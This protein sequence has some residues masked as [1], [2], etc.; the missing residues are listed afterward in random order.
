MFPVFTFFFSRLHKS[1][2]LDLQSKSFAVRA[3]ITLQLPQVISELQ[4][5]FHLQSGPIFLIPF[6]KRNTQGFFAIT[7]LSR[8]FFIRCLCFFVC[9]SSSQVQSLVVYLSL[10]VASV[11]LQFFGFPLICFE[12]DE[13]DFRINF[14]FLS[15]A[16]L[17]LLLP[18]S[19]LVNLLVRIEILMVSASDRSGQ[20]GNKKLC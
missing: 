17:L 13:F 1:L 8:R 12:V 18:P 20:P 9:F 16:K 7:I 5:T 19:V 2:K 4:V 11:C 15:G 14:F 6:V 3:T 10:L